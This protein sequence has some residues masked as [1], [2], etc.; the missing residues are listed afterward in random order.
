MNITDTH[1]DTLCRLTDEQKTFDVNDLHIS[2]SKLSNTHRYTQFF[3]CFI[4]PEFYGDAPAR[5]LTLIN[6]FKNKVITCDGVTQCTNFFELDNARKTNKLCAF[7]SIE[8]GECIDNLSRLE[9]YYSAGVRMIAPVWNNNNKLASGILGEHDYGL[10]DYG[11]Q[12]IL[13]MNKLGII[14]DVS[15]MSEKSFYDALKYTTL[16]PV[17]SHSCSKALC[18]HPRNLTDEQFTEIKNRNGYVGINFYPKFL[19][20]SGHSQIT[21]IIHHAEHFLELGGEDIIGL[22]S[23]FDGVDSLPDGMNS[24][25][26]IDKLINEMYKN[27]WSHCLT[28]KFLSK[29][30][31]KIIKNF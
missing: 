27:G 4:D 26:D 9:E 10:T 11:T 22:G 23:D 17:A 7:L 21:D 24:I 16:P 14:C 12:V 5:C 3:A 18:S 20:N 15:H 29:N 8:G 25:V 13:K 28:E 2:M 6:T 30:M 31:E 1:C 19:N